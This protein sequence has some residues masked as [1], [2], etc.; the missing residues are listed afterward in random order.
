ME[1]H[2]LHGHGIY[3]EAGDRLWVNLYVPTNARWEARGL[4]LVMET[5]FPEGEAA[6]LRLSMG[7]T[8]EFALVLR[9]PHWAGEGFRVSV[10]GQPVAAP[11]VPAGM[12]L[13][14]RSQYEPSPADVSTFVEVRRTWRDGDVV[15]VTLP[16]SLRIEAVPD[17]PRRAS[18]LWGPIVLAG[19][20]G[21]ER[22]RG[23]DAEDA[24]VPV[25]PVFVAADRPV[26]EWLKP[27]G[28][29]GRFRSE[30]AGREPNE[31]GVAHEVE[32]RPFYAL[33]RRTYSTYWDLFTPAEWEVKRAEYVAEAE[34]M[35]KLDAATVVYLEPGERVFE[36]RFGYE[37]GDGAEAARILGRPGRRARSWFSFRVPVDDAHPLA[38]L[39]THFSDERR[40][41]PADYEILV[42]GVKAGEAQV[43]RTDPPRFFDLEFA[44][45]RELV[46]GKSEVTL[47]FQ[48]RGGRW[49]ATV[50]G[51]RLIRADAPR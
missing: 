11:A 41:V 45:P 4:G 38:L 32:F 17:N 47:R 31:T 6:T 14:G 46:A 19:D 7:G 2:A 49:I 1:S 34:L 48:A 29:P 50:F 43:D 36:D 8:Q 22:A 44:V 25:A 37:G 3:Y 40:S 51:V 42:D 16:K 33:H 20:L 13:A 26:E 12:E 10:N 9:R 23:P 39:V 28:A 21:P 5:G 35:R 27:T 15:E 30:G 24:Q 18:L